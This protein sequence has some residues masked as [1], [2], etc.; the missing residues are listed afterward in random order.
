MS[1]IRHPVM[2]SQ[3]KSLTEE[4]DQLHFV[5]REPITL[6]S[7]YFV[8]WRQTVGDLCLL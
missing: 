3:S 8:V 1:F 5:L 6:Q 7:S 2:G 4:L